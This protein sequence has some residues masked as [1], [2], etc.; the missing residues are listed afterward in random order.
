MRTLG[1]YPGR[2]ERDVKGPPWLVPLLGVTSAGLVPWTLWLTFT[3]PERHL[4]HHYDV[5][6]VGFDIGLAAAFAAT[7]WAAIRDSR[8]LPVAAAV[9]ATMLLCD[10]WF[11]VVTSA[12][13]SERVEAI[14]Q[15]AFAE[16]PL[17]CVCAFVVRLRG[18][19]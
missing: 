18:R 14:L 6:W 2:R 4:A 17:A 12:G 16:I 5:A 13:G 1:G 11:D 8:W 9:T 7:T 19:T 10:A 15:A 3:L